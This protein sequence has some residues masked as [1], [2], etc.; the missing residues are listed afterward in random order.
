MSANHSQVLLD[1][2]VLLW[3]SEPDAHRG[4]SGGLS[5]DR[6]ALSV[7]LVPSWGEVI[8]YVRRRAHTLVYLKRCTQPF[9]G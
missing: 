3:R 4:S 8:G 5:E 2:M 6:E 1:G 9:R 7:V